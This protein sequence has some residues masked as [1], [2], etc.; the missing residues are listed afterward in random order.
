MMIWSSK[1]ARFLP[2]HALRIA[3]VGDEQMPLSNCK[4]ESSPRPN[5][6][7][8]ESLLHRNNVALEPSLWAVRLH[9]LSPNSRIAVDAEAGYAEDG[10]WWEILSAHS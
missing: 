10:A 7:G 8:V 2:T 4:E 1:K 6:E 5:G 9:V 3:E